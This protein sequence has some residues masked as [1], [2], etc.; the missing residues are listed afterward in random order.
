MKVG[1]SE[2]KKVTRQEFEKNLNMGINRDF[3]CK[4]LG[5]LDVFSNISE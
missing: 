3:K 1:V 4:T 5:F 2:V